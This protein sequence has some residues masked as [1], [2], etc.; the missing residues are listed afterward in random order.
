MDATETGP[1]RIHNVSIGSQ[2]SNRVNRPFP[3]KSEIQWATAGSWTRPT[4]RC[5][6]PGGTCI[7]PQISRAVAKQPTQNSEPRCLTAMP[8]SRRLVGGSWS[9][10]SMLGHH[11]PMSPPAR[12]ARNACAA[13]RVESCRASSIDCRWAGLYPSDFGR[14]LWP[15]GTPMRRSILCSMERVCFGMNSPL[16]CLNHRSVHHRHWRILD[17]GQR[18]MVRG[19]GPPHTCRYALAASCKSV[20]LS[21][22][23]LL[24]PHRCGSDDALE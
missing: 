3:Y 20:L 18:S 19:P 14:L 11:K 7:E 13:R 24:S 12:W 17:G 22:R 16:K 10:V 15:A 23:D 9:N 5:P 1:R 8:V 4:S 6:E 2:A 21:R